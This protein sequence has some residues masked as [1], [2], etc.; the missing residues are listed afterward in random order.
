MFELNVLT[1]GALFSLKFDCIIYLVSVCI[2]NKQ[3]S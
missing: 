2:F 1:V 3:Y